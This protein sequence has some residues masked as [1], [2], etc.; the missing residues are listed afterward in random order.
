MKRKAA[1][2]MTA[3]AV[4]IISSCSAGSAP[5]TAAGSVAETSFAAVTET[6]QEPTEE[7]AATETSE[8]AEETWPE[9][10]YVPFAS[11]NGFSLVEEGFGTEVTDQQSG[12]CWAHAAA[13]SIESNCLLRGEA[14][15]I[16][17][18]DIVHAA[19]GHIGV[20]DPERDGFHAMMYSMYNVGGDNDQIMAGI[21][22]GLDDGLVLTESRYY[23]GL[24]REQMQEA[25][26]EYGAFTIGYE[27]VSSDYLE[28]YGYTTLNNHGDWPDHAVTV[29]GYDDDFPAEYFEPQ[30]EQNGA[31][32]VQNSYSDRWGDG[33][34]FWLS[35]DTEFYDPMEFEGSYAYSGVLSYDGANTE[36]LERSG[37]I[38][39][40][41]VFKEEGVLGAVGTYTYDSFEEVTVEVYE[42]ILTDGELLTSVTAEFEYPG[43]HVIEL[44]EAITVDIFTVVVTYT[45]SAPVEGE[46]QEVYL[47]NS[48]VRFEA[49]SEPGESYI[50]IDGE[51][52][53]LTDEDI[54]NLLSISFIPNNACIKAL[55]I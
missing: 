38:S 37:G 8:P 31:W 47:D 23:G 36:W 43:Y 19:Y 51:W 48:Y 35:Y 54:Q 7:T 39:L 6:S 18:N 46:S 4:L 20:S 49:S 55:F 14:V 53:D 42:G 12:T 17:P 13:T 15:D 28:I 41:N 40:A 52:T 10:R 26:R 27:D 44:D 29:V 21:S 25:L 50:L 45:G 2:L 16:D 9:D 34:Y 1:A 11:G 30:A 3:S 24:S 22:N 5:E 32:L 33:G